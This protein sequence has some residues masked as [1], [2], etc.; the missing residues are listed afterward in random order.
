[1]IL[2]IVLYM[3][4]GGGF[5]DSRSGATDEDALLSHLLR[6]YKHM[7]NGKALV[8]FFEIEYLICS[9]HAQGLSSQIHEDEANS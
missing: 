6:M 4:K 3:S 8:Q 7:P 9:Y 5:G 2:R 1:M